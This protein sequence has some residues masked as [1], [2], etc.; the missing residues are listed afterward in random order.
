MIPGMELGCE[1]P[2]ESSPFPLPN[3]P[4]FPP[5]VV[6][7]PLPTV[8][9]V[10]LPYE[11]GELPARPPK[12]AEEIPSSVKAPEVVAPA[13][14]PVAGVGLVPFWVTVVAPAPAP[15]DTT[16]PDPA[17]VVDPDPPFPPW[18]L[19]EELP[20]P[21]EPPVPLPDPLLLLLPPVVLP[22]VCP[23]LLPPVDPP[24]PDPDPDPEPEPKLV[25]LP[26]PEDPELFPEFPGFE[27]EEPDP[28]VDDPEFEP[29]FE[30]EFVPD[31]DEP[32]LEDPES[33]DP[34]FPDP[35]LEP[36]SVAGGC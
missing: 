34:V 32:E 20:V 31:P 17:P 29:E 5:V 23:P 10:P 33:E 19:G 7:P 13:T 25:V 16:G 6:E 26:E 35:V 9:L 4:L 12:L 8:P 27:V 36:V 24:L 15:P 22:P 11:A 28:V 18:A 3:P 21:C 1:P 14:A 30:P 2:F